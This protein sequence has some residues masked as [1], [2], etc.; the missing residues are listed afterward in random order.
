LFERVQPILE[1]L[2]AVAG[3]VALVVSVRVV[4]AAQVE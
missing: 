3:V 2:A 1:A 4:A